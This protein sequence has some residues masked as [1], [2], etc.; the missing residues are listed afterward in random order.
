ME[1]VISCGLETSCCVSCNLN[2]PR[3]KYNVFYLMATRVRL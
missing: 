2:C 3:D 1:K